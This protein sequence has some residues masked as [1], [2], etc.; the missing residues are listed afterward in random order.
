MKKHRNRGGK[1]GKNRGGKPRKIR[2]PRVQYEFTN[3]D[4]TSFGGA[5]VLA[6]TAREFGLF[7]LLEGATSVKVR[8]RGATDRE[9]MWSMIASFAC[10]HGSLSDLDALR[11]DRGACILLGLEQAPEAR[12]AGE[13]LSRLKTG[14]VKGLWDAAVEFAGRVTLNWR[15]H[16]HWTAGIIPEGT[17][18]WLRGD[19]AYY[20]GDLVRECGR[21]GW[22][23]SVSLTNDRWKGP[24][25]E[26]LEG[27]PDSAWTDIGREE[28]AIFATH[29]PNGWDRMQ[30]YVVI[31]RR[32][33]GGQF[34]LTPSHTMI[35]VSR[36]DLPLGE[37]VHRHRGKQ[38][39]ENAFKGPLVDM[40]LHHP[41]CRGYRANQA[42]YALGQIAQVLLRAV[43]YTALPKKARR[44][45]IRPVIRFVMRT[46]AHLTRSARQWCV[47]FAKSNLRLDWL[48]HLMVTLESGIPSTC[49]SRAPPCRAAA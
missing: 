9:M 23:Y 25:L 26:Q 45:G 12:R 8:R 36:N 37:L 15:R 39:Q 31:R 2:P 27:L 33:Q 40:D 1:S 19:N 29:H 18:V 34:L 48:Y 20:Q 5:S 13:W 16:L 47:R 7:E 41:P 6:R 44:H 35:L 21:R 22:D 10:G 24:V 3:L 32:T 17:P 46:T 28:E 43:Q 42:F 11:A 4:L 30:H 38:G 49:R 14:D